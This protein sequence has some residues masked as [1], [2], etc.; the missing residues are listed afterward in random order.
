[1]QRENAKRTKTLEK[2]IDRA[3]KELEELRN[4]RYDPEY[5]HDYRKMDELND[6]I[7]EKH[8]EIAHL[9]EEWEQYAG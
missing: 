1:V 5:Y 6:R 9:M 2:Q 7:D 8:N 3:E 4:L